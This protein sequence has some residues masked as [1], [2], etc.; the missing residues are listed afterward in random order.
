M[1]KKEIRQKLTSIRLKLSLLPWES[2]YKDSFKLKVKLDNNHL[3]FEINKNDSSCEYF[4]QALFYEQEKECYFKHIFNFFQELVTNN[5][6]Y[7]YVCNSSILPQT[8]LKKL[9]K[10]GLIDIVKETD[11]IY[12]NK[13][14]SFEEQDLFFLI[15]L[16]KPYHID[17]TI[18]KR[19][20]QK[21][22]FLLQLKKTQ[23]LKEVKEIKEKLKYRKEELKRIKESFT[24][25]ILEPEEKI[26]PIL[27]VKH[28]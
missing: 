12:F 7:P 6:K 18:F 11:A 19:T 1:K 14:R 9:A 25:F 13:L 17:F 15:E 8:V 16:I 22:K 24:N 2:F 26:T 4:L 27:K 21:N 5:P 10:N 28:E 23:A 3:I 20:K